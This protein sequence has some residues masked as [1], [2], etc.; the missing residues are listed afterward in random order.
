MSNVD[1]HMSYVWKNYNQMWT[2]TIDAIAMFGRF[3]QRGHS[4]FRMRT[5]IISIKKKVEILDKRLDKR[6]QTFE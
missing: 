4:G 2:V 3:F 6:S 1:G 5:N